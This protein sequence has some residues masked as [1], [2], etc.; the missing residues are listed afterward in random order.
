MSNSSFK[1]SFFL[2]YYVHDFPILFLSYLNSNYLDEVSIMVFLL[3][4]S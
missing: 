1:G 4:Q 3:K 2:S